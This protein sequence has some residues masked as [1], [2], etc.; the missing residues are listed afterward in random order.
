MGL[1]LIHLSAPVIIHILLLVDRQLLV[2]VHGYHNFTCE[3]ER[4]RE[5]ER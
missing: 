3:R 1:S 2:R 4:E 5:R